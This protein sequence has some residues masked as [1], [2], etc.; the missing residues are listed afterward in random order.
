M[1]P[2]KRSHH[3][4]KPVPRDE[5]QTLLA[6]TRPKP[7]LSSEAPAQ[8]KINKWK[9]KKKKNWRG[10]GQWEH[11]LPWPTTKHI[12]VADATW[13]GLCK[14]QEIPALMLA[15]RV[16]D[17]MDCHPG[18]THE[19]MGP[20]DS[21]AFNLWSSH[22]RC[23][24]LRWPGLAQNHKTTCPADCFSGEVV[25][26][27]CWFPWISAQIVPTEGPFFFFF[28]ERACGILVPQPGLKPV[29]P[30]ETQES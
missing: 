19:L 17:G 8:P 13:A 12:W 9:E 20:W 4:D 23:W 29:P 28:G 14:G 5:E 3:N 18:G 2:N 16:R 1:E 30:V 22:D 7:S 27:V 26:G 25:R 21:K 11:T 15:W 6:A 24:I 10:G